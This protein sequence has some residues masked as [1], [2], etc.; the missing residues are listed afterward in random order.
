MTW[1]TQMIDLDKLK[2]H[3]RNY[4]E[5]PADQLAHIIASIEQHGIYRNIVV[6]EDYTILAG[7]GVVEALRQMGR[8]EAPVL[9]LNIAADTPAA[10]K[11]LTGDNA[12]GGL[13]QVDDRMFTELLKDIKDLDTL[14]GT[15]YDEMMLANLVFVT[16]TEEEVRDRNEAAEWAGAGMPD[17][18][19]A[20]L[21]HKL[22][23]S[24]RS[25]AD[26][27][28]YVDQ[29]GLRVDQKTKTWSTRWPWT[30]REDLSSLRFEASSNK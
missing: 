7:H 3:P 24:F 8:V 20:A 14:L 27:A 30:D 17:Y 15:G 4:R 25:E 16:R 12:L 22:V 23:I 6:A 19:N 29:T 18:E 2:P 21:P 10:L 13:A 26:R 1:P 11:V 28:R 5:H 9:K